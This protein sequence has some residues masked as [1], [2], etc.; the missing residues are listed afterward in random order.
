MVD[1]LTLMI[2]YTDIPEAS[3]ASSALQML[4]R[5]ALDT[6]DRWQFKKSRLLETQN[7]PSKTDIESSNQEKASRSSPETDEEIET[8]KG[9]GE[10]PQSPTF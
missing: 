8:M 5:K 6:D 1:N 4:K 10:Y 3:P 9:S 2:E 7:K